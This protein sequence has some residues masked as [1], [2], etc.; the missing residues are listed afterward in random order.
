M[1][2]QVNTVTYL[3]LLRKEETHYLQGYKSNDIYPKSGSLKFSVY[4][5]TL[6]L[7]IDFTEYNVI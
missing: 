7:F 6:D 3:I 2:L 4:S 1:M 5:S